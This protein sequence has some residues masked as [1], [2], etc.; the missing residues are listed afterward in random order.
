MI[1]AAV[2]AAVVAPAFDAFCFETL[3]HSLEDDC[4]QSY[5]SLPAV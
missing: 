3:E 4:C 5:S 1:A 2:A